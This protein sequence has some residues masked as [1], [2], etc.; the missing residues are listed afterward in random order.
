MVA[1]LL[2]STHI[3][4]SGLNSVH[5]TLEFNDTTM[6]YLNSFNVPS[7]AIFKKL[8]SGNYN[9]RLGATTGYK[10]EIIS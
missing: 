4:M 1:A 8:N 7:V 2:L 10:R 3:G 6:L 9:L 5:P